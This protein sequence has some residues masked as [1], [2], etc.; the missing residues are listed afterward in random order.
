MAP[1]RIWPCEPGAYP[2]SLHLI[3]AWQAAHHRSHP[4]LVVLVLTAGQFIS[5]HTLQQNKLRPY[6]IEREAYDSAPQRPPPPPPPETVW[7]H[8]QHTLTGSR[9]NEISVNV[10]IPPSVYISDYLLWS[11]SSVNHRI[12]IVKPQEKHTHT[13]VISISLAIHSLCKDYIKAAVQG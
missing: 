4:S 1:F 7:G 2:V 10:W 12:L 3:T 8:V 13:T 11:L 6:C 5:P 9:T